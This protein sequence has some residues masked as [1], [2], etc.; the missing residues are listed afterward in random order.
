MDARESSA[1]YP[2]GNFYP[3]IYGPSTQNHRFTRPRF[4]ACSACSPHSQAPFYPCAHWWVSVPP[5][6]TF[7]RL[8]YLLGGDR[9]S[10]TAHQTLSRRKALRLEIQTSQGGISPSPPPKPKPRFHRLPPI[11]RRNGRISMPDYSKA[12]WGL[13]V[14]PRVGCI[15]TASSISPGPSLRQHSDRYAF[16]AGRNLPDKEFRYLRTVIVTAAVHWGFGSGL[17][18]LPLTFQHRASVAPYTSTY[19]FAQS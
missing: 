15:F 10:Q 13:F 18:P 1:C 7:G 2:Q 19:V 16:R 17:A 11:L 14:L 4:R 3:L 12:P 9:P 6:G 5:E 8:R